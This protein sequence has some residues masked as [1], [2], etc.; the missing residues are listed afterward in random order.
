MLNSKDYIKYIKSLHCLICGITPVDPDHLEHLGMGG[1]N[2]SGL[3]DFSCINLCRVHH[4]ER[5]DLGTDRFEKKYNIN[6]WKEAF[7]LLR[8]YFT[9]GRL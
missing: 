4:R 6:L 9:N 8:R 5:H 7:N 3:K 1:A 2:K